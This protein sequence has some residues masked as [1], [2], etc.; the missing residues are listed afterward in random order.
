MAR[1]Y[2]SAQH[3]KTS[4]P[5]RSA[6]PYQRVGA[7]AELSDE[8]ARLLGRDPRP[9]L[10]RYEGTLIPPVRRKAIP[11]QDMDEQ[12]KV[13]RAPSSRMLQRR[14]AKKS[15]HRKLNPFMVTTGGQA[16]PWFKMQ[17]PSTYAAS[18]KSVQRHED[19]GKQYRVQQ[20]RIGVWEVMDARTGQPT[21][22]YAGSAERAQEVLAKMTRRTNPHRDRTQFERDLEE[23][24]DRGEV[25]QPQ[26]FPR[27]TDG[28]AM[29]T[30]SRP[31]LSLIHI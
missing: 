17:D 13:G 5:F 21:G 11:P 19:E 3:F 7:E 8:Y 28:M 2:G 29:K 1:S 9:E 30:Q 4:H 22:K 31:K 10:G 6:P 15:T 23:M 18:G 20:T 24:R 25:Y 16:V 26:P 14:T 12:F 27:P